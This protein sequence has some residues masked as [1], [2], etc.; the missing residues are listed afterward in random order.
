MPAQ[1]VRAV[2]KKGPV[3]AVT[4]RKV[5]KAG[6]PADQIVGQMRSRI[7]RGIDCVV[8]P[9]QRTRIWTNP[10]GGTGMW[11]ERKEAEAERGE[12]APK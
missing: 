11:R 6:G 2:K 9:Q 1:R 5:E 4:G 8:S 3:A 10:T 12:I 7:E